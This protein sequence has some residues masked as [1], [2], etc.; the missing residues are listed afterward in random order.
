[1]INRT[2][3]GHCGSNIH[4]QSD[5]NTFRKKKPRFEQ[6]KAARREAFPECTSPPDGLLYLC[7]CVSVVAGCRG[8]NQ[9]L[10]ACCWTA[11]DFHGALV[12]SEPN[13]RHLS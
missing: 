13:N 7:E 5:L 6:E 9:A 8:G 4:F 11:E 10:D 3:R 12:Y 1:M 2:A